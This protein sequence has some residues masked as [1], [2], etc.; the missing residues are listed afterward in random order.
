MHDMEDALIREV[1]VI[2]TDG[3]D[4]LGA[5]VK[6]PTGAIGVVGRVVYE[7]GTR[8]V[9]NSPDGDEASLR[10]MLTNLCTRL[11]EQFGTEMISMKF[12]RERDVSRSL[13]G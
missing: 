6:K 10:K 1:F 11:A 13:P 5:L 12:H 7:D 8:C 3:I 9:F 2:E 4:L